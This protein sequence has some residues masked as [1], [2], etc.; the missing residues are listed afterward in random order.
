MDNSNVG[1][2]LFYK[3]R[4]TWWNG[5]EWINNNGYNSEYLTKGTTTQRP[6]LSSADEGFE[7]Y[8]ST[9]KKKVLWNGTAWV[10]MD[11]SSLGE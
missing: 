9:L 8:D 10:N 7:Y 11:G 6:T 2:M 5:I 3:N 1:T 4:P